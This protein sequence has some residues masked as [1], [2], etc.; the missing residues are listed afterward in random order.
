[1]QVSIINRM[2]GTDVARV[3]IQAEAKGKV[4]MSHV[5]VSDAA[6]TPTDALRLAWRTRR[7]LSLDF[8]CGTSSKSPSAP[9]MGVQAAACLPDT[10]TWHP[11]YFARFGELR[12]ILGAT[13][14][15]NG[16]RSAASC[17]SWLFSL[18]RSKDIRKPQ[19]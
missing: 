16:K 9:V 13:K 12:T 18:P 3:T 14:N 19:L 4:K 1:M 10:E 15:K 5:R 11:R 7:W 2:T 6:A 17:S 8:L